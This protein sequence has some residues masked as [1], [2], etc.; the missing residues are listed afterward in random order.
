MNRFFVSSRTRALSS[1]SPPT[2]APSD[3]VVRR[4]ISQQKSGVSITIDD[5]IRTTRQPSPSRG[6]LSNI[7]HVTNLVG[8]SGPGL[9]PVRERL[10]C[11]CCFFFGS[12]R[13]VGGGRCDRSALLFPTGST[14]HS[15]PTQR[16]AQQN[17]HRGGGGL[18]DRQDQVSLLCHREYPAHTHTRTHTQ[19]ISVCEHPI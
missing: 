15:G 6:K 8:L 12:A 1:E 5:P 7:V 18:L 10:A 14:I 16:A 17:R 9:P 11:C 19:R 4:S 2:V 13:V 3:G